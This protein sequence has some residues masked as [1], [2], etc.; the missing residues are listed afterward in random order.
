MTN[1]EPTT[2]GTRILLTGTEAWAL[3]QVRRSLEA[4]G[5]TVLTCGEEHDPNGCRV[6]N[7]EACPLVEG[8]Q[9]AVT[10]R[11]HPL[12]SPVKREQCLACAAHADLPV[13]V[14]GAPSPNPFAAT[15]SAIVHGLNGV[16]EACASVRQASRRSADLVA[17]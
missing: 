13:L 3:D 4:A 9:V 11:A 7:G 14:A 17:H 16:S 10:V 6:A 2:R 5:D 1:D 8:A 15:T 12:A